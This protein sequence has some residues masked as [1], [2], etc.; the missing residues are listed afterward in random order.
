MSKNGKMKCAV[1]LSI[2]GL[3]MMGMIGIGTAASNGT[4]K[5]TVIGVPVKPSVVVPTN[6]NIAY[7]NPITK[8]SVF[9]TKFT[10]TMYTG[11][12]DWTSYTFTLPV[13]SY[14]NVAMSGTIVSD[15]SANAYTNW[16]LHTDDNQWGS[17]VDNYPT[18]S[19]F[20]GGY[21]GMSE[22]E[23]FY[24]SK[25]KHTVYL[26]GQTIAGSSGH[27]DVWGSLSIMAIPVN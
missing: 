24:L 5:Q 25:G 23:T 19:W 18:Y 10:K 26:Q 1:I 20:Q 21:M 7:T 22:Y 15:L 11:S 3:L 27:Y 13:A 6:T 12:G 8:I 2:L 17:Y 16:I 4:N 9:A 14:V